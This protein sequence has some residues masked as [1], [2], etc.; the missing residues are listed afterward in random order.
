MAKER[1]RR[2]GR[3]RR[4]LRVRQKVAGTPERPRLCVYKSLRH[5]YAQIIDDATGNTLAAASTLDDEVATG[6]D[7][8]ANVGAAKAVG[9]AIA[10]RAKAKGIETVVFDRS[11]YRY[12]GKVRALAEA[13]RGAGLS[14]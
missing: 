12:H 1:D 6:L 4:H 2:K 10:Q 8:T 11:G 3:R 13:A 5:I 14:F 7:G 9:E